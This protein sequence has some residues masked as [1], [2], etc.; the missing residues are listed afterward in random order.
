MNNLIPLLFSI[1]IFGGIF[2]VFRSVV[3]WY[4][5]VDKQVELLEEIRDLLKEQKR[6]Q[7]EVNES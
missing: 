1:I 7:N 5:K 2:M 3:L 4:L 6:S